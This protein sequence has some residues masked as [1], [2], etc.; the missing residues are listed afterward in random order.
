MELFD[1]Q[2]LTDDE[3]DGMLRQWD[4]PSAPARLRAAVFP[5][6]RA[7]WWQRSIRVP[8]PVAACVAVL[9]AAGTWRWVVPRERVTEVVYRE[10]PAEVLTFRELQPV[11]EFQPRIIR[12]G[13]V[14]N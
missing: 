7:R 8:L 10:K 5:E 1:N 2:E 12:R 6:T 11:T 14:E 9:L 3:L 13:H 4:A